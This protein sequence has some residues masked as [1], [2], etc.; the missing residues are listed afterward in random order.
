MNMEEGEINRE[1]G[2]GRRT[3]KREGRERVNLWLTI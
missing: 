1:Y 2:G 3:E